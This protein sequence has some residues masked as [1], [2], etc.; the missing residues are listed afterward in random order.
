MSWLAAQ[1][2]NGVRHA[3][4]GGEAGTP[5]KPD[6]QS[7]RPQPIARRRREPRPALPPGIRSE[8]E[9][10]GRLTGRRGVP[11]PA[12][13]TSSAKPT[14]S[15]SG[16]RSRRPWWTSPQPVHARPP[17]PGRLGACSGPRYAGRRLTPGVDE[18]DSLPVLS[19]YFDSSGQAERAAP[20]ARRPKPPRPAGARPE[21]GSSEAQGGGPKGGQR[22]RPSRGGASKGS[23]GNRR[24][25]AVRPP[26]TPRRPWPGWPRSA[27]GPAPAAQPS[28][29]CAVH[30]TRS[31]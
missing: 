21:R 9:G 16:R 25:Q 12:L 5:A 14:P 24:D 17:L 10:G 19:R 23:I 11:T 13:L 27:R 3:A 1:P 20:R 8:H 30:R 2:A 28:G 18:V 26:R 4:H 22:Q 7:G 29:H 6:S 15:T 31:C